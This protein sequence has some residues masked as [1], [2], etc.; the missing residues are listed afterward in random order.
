MQSFTTFALTVLLKTV[1]AVQLVAQ[2]EID[3]SGHIITCQF[4]SFI[5]DEGTRMNSG[6]DEAW[7]SMSLQPTDAVATL[8][9]DERLAAT[10]F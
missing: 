9:W 1:D 7:Q 6:I 4:S 10:G 2:D 3:R 8:E 5:N